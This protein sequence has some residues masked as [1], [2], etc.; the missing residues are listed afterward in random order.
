M[1][2]KDISQRTDLIKIVDHF[3]EKVRKDEVLSRMFL[4]VNWNTHLPLMY[5]FW[6]NVMF[7]TGNYTGN[8]MAKHYTSHQKNPMNESHFS[9]WLLLF[10]KSV[11]ELFEGVNADI[12][13]ER[14]N[15]IATI[16]R[17]K[18]LSPERTSLL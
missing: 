7:H 13:K 16:M 11:D 15:S 6:D 17:L 3:Y 9:R 10:G 14:A 12:L 8:P 5:D 4:H 1:K 2:R 18:I